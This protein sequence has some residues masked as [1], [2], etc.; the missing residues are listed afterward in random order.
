MSSLIIGTKYFFL[1]L[2]I[3]PSQ[4]SFGEYLENLKIKK[5]VDGD[6]VYVYSQGETLKVRLLEIDA[7]EMNQPYGKQA[8]QYLQEL[9]I[10]GLVD[11]D[12]SGTD[13]YKRKLGRLYWKELDINRLMVRS[14][15]AWVYDRYVNDQTFY[16]DQSHAKNSKKGFW[17]S[18]DPIQPWE[19]RKK[20]K[21]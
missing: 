8:K 1:V 15:Y 2:L 5:V 18:D 6:T 17:K 19:W 4:F 14:G 11:L 9:L 21:K 10:E 3:C 12:I 20:A 16:E 13:I 7:P